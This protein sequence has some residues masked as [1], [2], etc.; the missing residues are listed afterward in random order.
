[1]T[2]AADPKDVHGGKLASSLLCLA[3]GT[4]VGVFASTA[5]AEQPSSRLAA[6]PAAPAAPVTHHA[7]PAGP[8]RFGCPGQVTMSAD[9]IDRWI[10]AARSD[11]TRFGYPGHVTMSADAI[12]RLI[13]HPSPRP[14]ITCGEAGHA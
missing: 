2:T 6:V 3:T 8:A 13:L 4:L 12:E 7:D 11:P 10:F 1:M 9:A 14:P 5:F